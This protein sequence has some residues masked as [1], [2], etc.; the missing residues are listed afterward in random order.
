MERPPLP[1]GWARPIRRSSYRGQAVLGV[2]AEP[3]AA[4]LYVAANLGLVLGAWPHAAAA[5]LLGG[6]LARRLTARDPFW[7]EVT[8]QRAA[9][10]LLRALSTRGRSWRLA[11]HWGAR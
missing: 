10:S 8:R 11:R 7:V 9:A 1:E 2:P 4:L 6:W 5:L 3:M